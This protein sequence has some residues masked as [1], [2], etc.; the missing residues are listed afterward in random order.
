MYLPSKHDRE[1]FEIQGFI[2]AYKKL[3]HGRNF[4]V[5][6][7]GDKPD[8]VVRDIVTDERFG[9]ELTSVYLGDRSVPDKH[10]ESDS[11]VIDFSSEEIEQYEKRIIS[12]VIDKVCKARSGYKTTFPIILSV[13]VNEYISLYMGEEYWRSFAKRNGRIFDFIDPFA[14]VVF[15]PL[16]N[17]L[18]VSVRS[19]K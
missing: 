18:V 11:D 5:E 4:V 14:E 1:N 9:V 17:D 3:K 16:P 6:S 2:E 10:M 13:Y 8:R 12:A 15:W 19:G 7:E